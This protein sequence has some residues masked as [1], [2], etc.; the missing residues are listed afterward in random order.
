MKFPI[1]FL[2]ASRMGHSFLWDLK[3][4][5]NID[6]IASYFSMEEMFPLLAFGLPPTVTAHLN[7]AT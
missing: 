5:S 7:N 2:E 3:L 4:S 1:K 6:K